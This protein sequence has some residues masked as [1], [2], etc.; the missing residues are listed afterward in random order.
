MRVIIKRRGL[1]KLMIER[2][3]EERHRDIRIQYLR[4]KDLFKMREI[5]RADGGI[6]EHILVFIPMRETVEQRREKTKERKQAEEQDYE[7]EFCR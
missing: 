4:R 2:K 6:I 7:A 5:E 1:K 3:T